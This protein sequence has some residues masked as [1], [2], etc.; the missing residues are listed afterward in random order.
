[1]KKAIKITAIVLACIIGLAILIVA[2]YVIYVAA[3]YYRIEDNIALEVSGNAQHEKVALHTDYT[4]TTYNL[5]FGAYSPEYSFF[6][7]TGVM[8][9]GT[10]V[11]GKYA[12]GMNKGDVRKNVDGQIALAKENGSDFYFF[13]EVDEDS[14]RSYHINMRDEM[15]SALSGYSSAY[16]QNFHTADLLYPFSDPIG[17]SK[18]GILTMSRYQIES[19][20]RR[21][22]PIDTS[23]PDKFF[24]LDR[25]FSLSYV[26]IEGS[27][28]Y[29]TLLNLHMSAY[30]EGG[31]IRAKQLEMLNEVLKFEAFKGN[32]VIAGGDF[33]HCFIADGFATD[34]EAL[35]YF[36]SGQKV[37]DWVKNSI[38]HESEL[39]DGYKIVAP[40]NAATCRGADIPYKEG[41]NYSTVIDGFLVTENIEIVKYETVDTKYA[42]SDHNPVSFK[43]RLKTD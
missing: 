40:K 37:P 20:V 18:S 33:N 9:D 2:G 12:K 8:N 7:D 39:T 11:E 43:F 22:F 35:N 4:I 26:P 28:K 13:Q 24:D 5:G 19:S 30:D 3:Q 15:R 34:E 10:K 21:S 25:C 16:A 42:Y 14:D 41:V 36:P 31:K 6:M 23:F 32:Y 1:M 27:D 38:L 17:K 29:L